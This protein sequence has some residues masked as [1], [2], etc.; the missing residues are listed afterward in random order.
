MLY[1]RSVRGP[2]SV[3]R[4]LWEQRDLQAD[5]RSCFQYVL[6]LRDKLTEC[7]KLA[8]QAADVS[9][10]RYKSY[11]DVRSQDRQFKPGD[12]VLVLLP[13]ETSKL[14]ISWSGPYKVLERRGK[15]DYLIELPKGPKLYHANLLKRYHRRAHVN[16]AAEIDEVPTLEEIPS[17]GSKTPVVSVNMEE[18]SGRHLP[19]TPDGQTDSTD[20]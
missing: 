7:S 5:E 1:G 17:T 10:A 20:C 6:E 13:H 4:D 18:D 14:L 12:E 2:L 19:V 11:F 3:L 9:T 8:A 16:F 15:V